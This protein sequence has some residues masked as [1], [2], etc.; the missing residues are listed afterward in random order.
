MTDWILA[1]E[2]VAT[3]GSVAL[4]RAGEVVSEQDLPAESRSA[5]TLAAGIR[6]IW[7]GAGR[8][9]VSLVAV[10]SGPGSFTGL[11]VGITTAK[12]LAYGW[13]TKLLGVG[14]L[15]AI[16]AQAP[17][18]D[19][20]GGADLQAVIDAQRKELFVGGFRFFAGRWQRVGAD[21][22]VAIDAWLGS[23]TPGSIVTGPAMKKLLDRVRADVSVVEEAAWQPGAATVGKLAW[24]AHLAGAVDELWTLAPEYLRASYA[25]ERTHHR[26]AEGTELSSR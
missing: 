25:E 21:S 20:A 12:A 11:R 15:D 22:I 19:L 4:L 14:T 9:L 16:A 7:S 26:G 10:A 13:G 24:E 5:R 2:T 23:L 3:A 6:E 18:S 17:A 8:P 1:I